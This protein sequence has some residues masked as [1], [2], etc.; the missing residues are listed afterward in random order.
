LR[1]DVRVFRLDR[2]LQA[3][4]LEETFTAPEEFDVQAE[5]TRS[6]AAAYSEWTVEVV[7]DTT[8]GE[9]RKRISA[10]VGSLE[11]HPEGVLLR[12][13]VDT[14]DWA[15]HYLL[16]LPWSVK[17]VS[18]PELHQALRRLRGRIDKVLAG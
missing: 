16:G 3:E 2:V 17:V 15:A 1:T 8:L 4:L 10:I 12:S 5:L 18:P 6:L 14:L 7:L 9:A 11:P 13:R